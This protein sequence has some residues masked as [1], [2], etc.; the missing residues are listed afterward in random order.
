MEGRETMDTSKGVRF[1]YSLWVVLFALF[2]NGCI[3]ASVTKHIES[4]SDLDKSDKDQAIVFG[5]IEWIEDGEKKEIGKD[6]VLEP[7]MLNLDD[8]SIA[9]GLL[10]DDGKF[11]WYLP[12]GTYYIKTIVIEFRGYNVLPKVA[13][14]VPENGKAYYLG[15]LKCDLTLKGGLPGKPSGQPR[16]KIND[17]SDSEITSFQN[18]YNYPSDKIEMSLMIHEPTLPDSVESALERDRA[19]QIINTILMGIPK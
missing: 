14:S 1:I 17:E 18:Q 13:F 8:E 9:I 10:G 7:H 15:T 19:V 11:V 4:A 5:Q 3:S 16:C 6:V 2:L 12:A